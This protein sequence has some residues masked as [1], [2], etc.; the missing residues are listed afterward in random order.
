MCVCTPG[1]PGLS[2]RA[3]SLYPRGLCTRARTLPPARVNAQPAL[4]SPHGGGR[5]ISGWKEQPP[6]RAGQDPS[7]VERV[8]HGSGL[9]A[10]PDHSEDICRGSF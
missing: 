6:D 1:C 5:N 3:G 4:G 9:L 7:A 8:L 2:F 10:A